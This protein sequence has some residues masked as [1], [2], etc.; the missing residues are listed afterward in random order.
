MAL[1]RR[2]LLEQVGAVSGTASLLAAMNLLGLTLATPV[3][4]ASFALAPA[5]GK[6]KSVVV[7]GAGIAGLV[8][9][10]EL[11]RAGYRVT[12][13]EAR[14][15][16]GGRAWTIRGGD[17]VEQVDRP[18]QRGQFSDGLYFN[19]G[20]ARIP[21]WHHAILGYAKRLNV[22]MEVFVNSHMATGWDFAGKVRPGRQMVNDM[23]GRIAELL[24]KAIDQG[25]LNTAMP[26]DELGQF[27]QFLQF[28]GGLDSKG[29]L[30]AQASSG[31]A[32][33]PGGYDKPGRPL[34]PLTIKEMLPSRGAAFPQ[35]FQS[36]ID[37]QPTMMQPVG[38]MDRIARALHAAVEPSVVLNE[39][40][41]AI[42]REGTGVRIEHR[43]GVTRA[44]YAV[45][46]VPGHLLERISK[47]FSP[48]KKTALKGLNYLKSAK[49]AFE[50]PRF[51]EDDGVYGGVAW[52]DRLNENVIYPS[53]NFHSARGVVVGAYVAGWTH[54][55]T[56]EAFTKLPIAEQIRISAGSLEALHP[57]KS[58]LLERPVA[59][60]WGQVRYSEGVGALWGDGPGDGG[61]R[62]A[63]YAELLR[64]E[65]PIVFAGE[66]LSYQGL[67][68]EGAALSAHE[69][70]KVLQAMATE[71]AGS[72]KAA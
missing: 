69:A 68:Q 48:A 21:S 2:A 5:S 66:H 65:G 70:L 34:D 22:P 3:S 63:Q 28:Y 44:D 10:Y 8:A 4:A 52:T 12:V 14:D 31:F 33:W 56:P 54:Q 71:K 23:Q 43:S 49:V 17:R 19:P 42:R 6:G 58:R 64:P 35:I 61:P 30:T 25:A 40:V 72:A 1:T 67:W 38:G 46:T 41:S 24:A 13:L 29:V 45:V 16:V 7:L 27:R 18:L 57:G 59:V 53:D 20:P 9:A 47:D 50:A 32:D 51:W 11:Q 39:P 36:I 55:D 26:K 62:G 15:R 37:M 60:N